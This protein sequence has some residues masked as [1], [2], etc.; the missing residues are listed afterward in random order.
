[1]DQIDPDANVV[2][3]CKFH[4]WVVPAHARHW[5]RIFVPSVNPDPE[6]GIDDGKL[7]WKY[8]MIYKNIR[9]LGFESLFH[10]SDALNVNLVKEIYAN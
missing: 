8:S 2:P 5:Y 7:G 3:E 9:A 1:M 6:V 10:P 4:I